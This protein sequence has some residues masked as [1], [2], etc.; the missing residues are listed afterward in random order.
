MTVVDEKRLTEKLA[1]QARYRSGMGGQQRAGRRLDEQEIRNQVSDLRPGLKIDIQRARLVTQAY[2]E[3]DG[4]PIVIRRAKALANFLDNM[5][6]YLGEHDRIVGNSSRTPDH[7]ISYPELYSRWL[8]KAIDMGYKSMLTDEERAEMHEINKYWLNKSTQGLERFILADEDK[9]YWSYFNQ[10]VFIWVHGYHAGQMPNYEKLFKIGLKGLLKQAQDKLAEIKSDRSLIRD[11][12][13]E[14]LKKKAFLESVIISLEAGIRWSKRYAELARAMAR[15][16]NSERRKELEQIAEACEWVPENPPRTFFEALQFWYFIFLINRVIDM[17]TAGIGDRFDYLFYPFFKKD[18]DEGRITREDAQELLEHVW[19]KLTEH[20]D[21]NP[22]IMASA[23]KATLRYLTIGG[24]DSL[25]KDVTNELTYILMDSV[26]S[27]KLT[28]PMICVRLHRN[29]PDEFLYRFTDVLRQDAG[30]YGIFNDEYM[31]PY[32][33]SKGIPPQDARNWAV[34][35]CLRHTVVGKPMSHR[36]ISGMGFALPKCME[37]ALNQGRDYK[38]FEGKQIGYPTPDPLT[39]T[40]IEDAIRAYLKQVKFFSEKV[41]MLANITDAL[42]EQW[43]PQPFNSAMLDGCIQN[44]TDLR[45]LHYWHKTNMQ[46]VGQTTVVNS[47]V[48]MKKLV[49]EDK[50]ATMAELLQA[51]RDNWEGHEELRRKFLDAPKFGNDDDYVD[52]FARNV[53]I[54]TCQTMH[55][56]KTI[57]GHNVTCDGSGSVSYFNFSGFT[58]ATPD[59]R[60]DRDLFND[61]TI[62]PL[63]GTD[64]K[65]PTAVLKSVAK[66]EPLLTFNH[67]FNQRWTPE[68]LEGDNRSKF[69]G[70]LRTFVDLGIHHIQGNVIHD[71]VLYDAQKHP[72]DHQDLIVR[73]AGF[74]AYF[75]DLHKE[76]QDQLISRTKQK[77]S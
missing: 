16:A 63:P 23:S 32:L 36:A 26:K 60:Q 2:K 73:I 76:V 75:I 72:E 37:Y 34:E 8:D 71:K 44:A 45:E 70:Y 58:G 59:G 30:H 1:D 74:S 13:R 7:T 43:L 67:L 5:S 66:V 65:G 69:V 55:A 68:S 3:N 46:P 51:L 49:F 53:H 31:V 42:E 27:L 10:G 6:L 56:F 39:F 61:G 77:L 64:K 12:P 19:I 22:P 20:P 4:E 15:E 54:R 21:L 47:L 41:V 40:S 29:T 62:S 57:Y 38:F 48:A 33:M 24:Q 18:K 35:D 14:F 25:G 50:I 52:L 28:E 11:N 9:P 17:Q